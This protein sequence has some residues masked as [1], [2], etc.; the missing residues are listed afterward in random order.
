MPILRLNLFQ[1]VI[2]KDF[3]TEFKKK[4]LLHNKSPDVSAYINLMYKIVP[5]KKAGLLQ[6][7][8]SSFFEN[9]KWNIC[10]GIWIVGECAEDG[11]APRKKTVYT[12]PRQ[13]GEDQPFFGTILYIKIY[14][15]CAIV[16]FSLENLVL[17]STYTSSKW[18]GH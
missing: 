4:I 15:Y 10:R 5:P 6:F 2:D 16:I 3:Q 7:F 13:F 12:Q 11:G 1:P 17:N 14:V 18:H 9:W 8:S